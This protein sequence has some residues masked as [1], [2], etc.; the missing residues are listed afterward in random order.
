MKKIAFLLV[1][2]CMS[3]CK[4]K[5]KTTAISAP[6][7]KMQVL[8]VNYELSEMSL[9][10]HAQLGQDVV[11]NFALGKIKG[12]LGKTFIGNLENGVFGGVY[13]FTD[14]GSLAAYSTSEL[15][16]GI[17]AHP[18][19][20]NFKKESYAVAGISAMSNGLAGE[21]K[22]ATEVGIES[23]K[24][25]LIVNYELSEMS[26]EAHAQ[27]GRD[28]VGNFAPGKVKGL[29]GKTFIGNP[30]KG[31]FGG[32]YYF[33]NAAQADRYLASDLWKGIEAHPN[34]VNFKTARFGIAPISMI[35]NGVP[36]L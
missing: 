17:V 13:Y 14:K 8:T 11:G 5:V 20:V 10:A 26:I 7:T 1:L 22:T 31:V 19:L 16:E 3:S 32:V 29:I 25:V 12:L 18:N 15:W 28:V 30:E 35:A 36:S 23:A 27:L 21:R 4:D 34:L 24:E 33:T 6:A 2:A 9:E